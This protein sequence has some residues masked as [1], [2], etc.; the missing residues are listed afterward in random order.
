MGCDWTYTFRNQTA[1]PSGFAE[2]PIRVE[3]EVQDRAGRDSDKFKLYF[4]VVPEDWGDDAPV[5]E[6]ETPL[7]GST[8]TGE[9]VWVNGSVIS[10]SEGDDVSIEAALDSSIL[11]ETIDE[12]VKQLHDG[13]FADVRNL[14]DGSEFSLKLKIEDL[15]NENG[16]IQTIYLKV[17]EGDGQTW[18]LYQQIDINLPPVTPDDNSGGNTDVDNTTNTD[19]KSEISDAILYGGIGLVVLLLV[20]IVSLLVIR[21]RRGGGDDVTGFAGVAGMDPME[22]YVQQLIAQGYPEDTAR[23]YAQ[24][25]AGHFQD[26]Q[27]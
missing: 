1:D 9:Y 25:Y 24:Q 18:T 4:V 2:N 5:W 21:S 17:V 6:I 20:F 7:D 15:Y 19:T 26:Q 12:K 16:S 8:Q 14:G 27:Q 11:N 3:L 23:Q 13:K 22:A 10:G